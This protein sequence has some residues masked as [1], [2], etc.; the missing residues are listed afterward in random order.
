MLGSGA[1]LQTAFFPSCPLT[2]SCKEGNKMQNIHYPS[3][4]VLVRRI[5]FMAVIIIISFTFGAKAFATRESEHAKIVYLLNAIGSSDLVFIRNGAEYTGEEAKA[6]C[7]RR[8][9]S[10]ATA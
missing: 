7:K 8:W 4:N 6:I 9:M 5:L 3:E 10:S 2:M 1:T